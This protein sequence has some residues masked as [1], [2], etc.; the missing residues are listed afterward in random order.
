ML[1]VQVHGSVAGETPAPVARRPIRVVRII[2]RLNVGGPA[3]HVVWLTSGLDQNRFETHLVT[4]TVPAGE[5]DM[6]Y[7]AEAAGI[8]PTVI[9]EMSRELGPRDVVAFVR[10]VRLLRQI[11]PDVVHTHK[12]KAG[13]VG[14]A[15]A[16]VYRWATPSALRLRPRPCRVVHTYH[17][18]IFNSYYG[19]LKTRI[20]LVIER[21][22]ARLCTDRI[23]V[24]S[25]QQRDEIVDR[26]RV[27]ASEQVRVV[28]LGLDLDELDGGSTRIRERLGLT[29][30]TALVGI[31]GRLTEVKDHRTFLEAVG[32]LRDMRAPEPLG[33]RF[34]VVGDGALRLSLEQLADRLDLRRDVVFLGHRPDAT[35]L[36]GD[37][38]IAALTSL[39]EGTPLSLIEALCAGRP[40]V[41]TEVGGV[42]DLLG[43]RRTSHDG[44]SIWDHGVSSPPRDP[45]AFARALRY[46]IERPELRKDMGQRGREFAHRTFT[47]ERLFRDVHALYDEIHAARR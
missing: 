6:G 2:D 33:A 26:Y 29:P 20:F 21:L 4:G 34:A 17:G 12:A 27:A 28:P 35:A 31:V 38:D 42:P 11:G 22:L 10:L 45:A 44:F 9:S 1:N 41:A 13:A 19:P 23:V 46:L 47:K 43:R 14:R 25:R 15:A 3:K 30:D 37:L 39:N 32:C 7:F 5:S 8:V 24:V 36:A 40:V 18:H 16:F